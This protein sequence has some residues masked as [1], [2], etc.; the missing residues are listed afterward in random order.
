MVPVIS[1]MIR[2][3]KEQKIDFVTGK[4]PRKVYAKKGFNMLLRLNESQNS[5]IIF[6]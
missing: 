1:M 4:F 5:L 3:K 6:D 2:L